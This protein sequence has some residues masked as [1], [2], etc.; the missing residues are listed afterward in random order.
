MLFTL[1]L[2]Y[3]H[4]GTMVKYLALLCSNK[5]SEQLLIMQPDI[6]KTVTHVCKCFVFP[7]MSADFASWHSNRNWSFRN[8]WVDCTCMMILSEKWICILE[9][10]A[11]C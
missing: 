11:I 5:E 8:H 3:N 2:Q 7:V 9:K 10:N 4:G 1:Q 6:I